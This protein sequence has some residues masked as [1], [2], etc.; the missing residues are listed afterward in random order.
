MTMTTTFGI[1]NS[2]SSLNDSRNPSGRTIFRNSM[3]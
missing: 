3:M 2:T 1:V